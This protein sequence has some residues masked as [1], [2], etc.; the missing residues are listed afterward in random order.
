MNNHRESTEPKSRQT[1]KIVFLCQHRTYFSHYTCIMWKDT[2]RIAGNFARLNFRDRI[3]TH[4][5]LNRAKICSASIL[6]PGVASYVSLALL[7]A[8]KSTA[9]P[10]IEHRQSH[11]C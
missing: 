5:N 4:E 10:L 8:C 3:P 6:P 2:Y 11:S 7:P 1:A 9:I